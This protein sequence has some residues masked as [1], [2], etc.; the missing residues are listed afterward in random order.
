LEK[1]L[2]EN[3]DHP[4]GLHYL[5]HTYDFPALADRGLPAA[6]HYAD[7]APS[8][9]HALHMPSHVFSMLG[10]WEDSIRSNQAALGAAKDYVHAMDFMVY[11]YLQLAQDQEAKRL[12]E[13]SGELRKTRGAPTTFSPT[14]AVLGVYTAFA[15][16]PA[17]YAI[18]RGDW[19]QAASLEIQPVLPAADAITYF[20]RAMGSIRGG[21][22][23]NAQKDIE[24][25][26]K[27][28]QILIESKQ[29]YWAQQVEIQCL[30]AA[31]WQLHREKK[32]E[33]AIKMMRAAADLEDASEKHV[34]MENRLWPMRELLAEMLLE[35]GKPSEAFVEFEASLK[36][37]PNRFRT[38]YGAARAADRMGDQD[39]ARK[40]FEKLVELSSHSDTERPELKEAKAFLSGTKSS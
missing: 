34:A 27:T 13:T 19:A 26:K 15:A 33:E 10:M 18:E 12:L 23:V 37:A 25:L 16:I 17:R 31:G 40:Y 29:D 6:R 38:F 39:Q 11:A 36:N 28:K 24:Q 35:S 9:P 5:I 7:V 20:S 4:G 30:A 14:G 8:A 21:D 1:V 22:L 2:S 3:P 32:N